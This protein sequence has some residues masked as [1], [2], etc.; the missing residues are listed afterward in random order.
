MKMGFCTYFSFFLNITLCV[1]DETVMQNKLKELADLLF[2]INI[3]HTTR[4]I[5]SQVV[6]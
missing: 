1:N 3:C 5:E 2:I 4:G 6:T